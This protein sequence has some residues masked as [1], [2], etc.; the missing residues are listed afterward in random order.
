MLAKS[1]HTPKGLPSSAAFF[2]ELALAAG[3]IG[4]IYFGLEILLPPI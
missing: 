4:L 2:L 3:C 1:I